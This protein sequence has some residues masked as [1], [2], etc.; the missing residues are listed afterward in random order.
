VYTPGA[1]EFDEVAA[2]RVRLTG[3]SV[4]VLAS[5]ERPSV[6]VSRISGRP[7]AISEPGGMLTA[8]YQEL[9][10]GS[11][12]R[13]GN[14]SGNVTPRLPADTSAQVRLK[15]MPGK[16]TSD[17]TSLRS[18][19]SPASRS[20]HGKVGAGSGRVSVTSVSGHITLLGRARVESEIR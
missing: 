1:F 2:L 15:S 16:I 12:I 5:D 10:P 19:R 6:S 3:G 9:A 13:A 14:V 17:F 20:V 8:A 7:L 11:S 4:A 18:A